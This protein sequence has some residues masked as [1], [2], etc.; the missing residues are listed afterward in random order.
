MTVSP[1]GRWEEQPTAAWG[2]SPNMGS[3]LGPAERLLGLPTCICMRSI[4][5]VMMKMLR[6]CDSSYGGRTECS[7]QTESRARQSMENGKV[8]ESI[9]RWNRQSAASLVCRPAEFQM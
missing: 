2:R 6:P 9:T 5:M 3:T 8:S 1:I 4:T 7:N